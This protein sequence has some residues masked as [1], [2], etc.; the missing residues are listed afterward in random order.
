MVGGMPT[1]YRAALAGLLLLT[2][3]GCSES[4]PAAKG[5]TPPVTA[6]PSP[7]ASPSLAAATVVD[8]VARQGCRALIHTRADEGEASPTN[9]TLQQVAEALSRSQHYSLRFDGQ[10]LAKRLRA[11]QAQ[12]DDSVA[13]INVTQWAKQVD[14]DCTAFHAQQAS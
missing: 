11:Y 2:I 10:E 3:A 12:P 7:S 5:S 6:S 9:P 8:D 1:A 4:R 13:S 14:A